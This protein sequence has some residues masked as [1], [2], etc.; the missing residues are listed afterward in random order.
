MVKRV[1]LFRPSRGYIR[2]NVLKVLKALVKTVTQFNTKLTVLKVNSTLIK[3]VL[4]K[5]ILTR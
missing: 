4:K 3:I 5:P 2:L 1:C